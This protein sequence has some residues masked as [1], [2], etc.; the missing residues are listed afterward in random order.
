MH[1]ILIKASRLILPIALV[2]A[3]IL[4]TNSYG[5]T[6]VKPVTTDT[7]C[8]GT[9]VQ[10][11]ATS[12]RVS[13]V[14]FSWAD[15][16]GASTV[17]P[18]TG[19]TVSVSPMQ[20][21]HYRVIGDSSGV[22]DTTFY[23]V[24]VNALPVVKMTLSDSTPCFRDT[25]WLYGS[26]AKTYTWGS[27]LNDPFATGD[28]VYDI[29]LSPRRYWVT[30][31]DSNGCKGRDTMITTVR[32]LP[33]ETIQGYVGGFSL[34]FGQSVC[35]DELLTIKS[36]HGRNTYKW[37]PAAIVGDTTGP[38]TTLMVTQTVMITARIDSSNGCFVVFPLTYNPSNIKPLLIRTWKSDSTICIGDTAKVSMGGANQY[39]WSPTATVV[40]TTAADA[41]FFPSATTDYT[42][43]GFTNGCTASMTL[44]VGVNPIPDIS[45]SQSSNG[46]VL[47]VDVPD[48]IT[49][50]SNAGVLFDWGFG[51]VSADKIKTI[52]PGKTSTITVKAISA[53]GCIN[54]AQIT[55]NVDTT[56]GTPLSVA[57]NITTGEIKTY[58]VQ[59]GEL[60]IEFGNVPAGRVQVELIGM[61]GA[62]I[63]RF[64]LQEVLSNDKRVLDMPE[65]S[66]GLFLLKISGEEYE[67]VNKI[68]R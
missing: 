41:A 47:C 46:K 26:G 53:L 8:S 24:T 61:T 36:S 68:M 9:T 62:T 31:T 56:C 10:L 58:V 44:K 14:S 13:G 2:S 48:T 37:S 42:V 45:L 49:I 3:V 38:Q 17:S 50:T 15:T 25:L 20:T 21:T 7:I 33:K 32:Q 19:D 28:T 29:A 12:S 57:G 30:G 6:T 55:I 40:D 66:R 64:D 23:T 1:N 27:S 11:Y 4:S 43:K 16:T 39:H 67:I 52:T 18:T 54:D 59:N 65:I 22:K 34:G 51:V 60:H 63:K 5:Q 35:F